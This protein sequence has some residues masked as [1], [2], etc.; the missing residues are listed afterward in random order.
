MLEK[1]VKEGTREIPPYLPGRSREEI[2]EEYS[3]DENEIIKLASNE[4]P[5]GP[6]PI[7]IDEIKK[8]LSEISTYPDPTATE[9]R[10]KISK[11]LDLDEE[12]VV[13]GNGSDEIMELVFKTFLNPGEEVVIPIP[14]F[15]LYENLT[16]AYS[17]I[18][19]LIPQD[20]GFQF[21][22][23]KILEKINKKTKLV[24]ICSPNNP[25]GSVILEEDLRKI[26]KEELVVIL[27]EAYVEF[28]DRSLAGLVREYENLVVLRTFSKAFGL[29]GLRVGYGLA[30]KRI[31]D[32]FLRVKLPFN[33]NILALRAAA[34]ALEDRRFLEE[35]IKTAKEG[36]EFLFEE[37]S[38]IDRVKVHPSKSNFLLIRLELQKT[39]KEVTEDLFKRGII[40]RDCAHFKGLDGEFIRVSV[41]TMED[42]RR[43]L[44]C[45]KEV[46]D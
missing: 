23:D 10:T 2:A 45:L 42:N 46:L 33:V 4:N 18:P 21:D 3:L 28:A 1:L 38:K 11:Y 44:E 12:S 20:K 17:G 27:D 30:D 14:T 35:S 7:A 13:V 36:R 31:I 15:P 37:L 19:V 16:K 5:L 25:T 34:G 22:V 6:S 9:L 26:L 40:V 41:G 29:A 32:Y 43:F 39:S 8:S 24:F